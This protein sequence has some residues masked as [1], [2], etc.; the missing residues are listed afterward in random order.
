[1]T[2]GFTGLSIWLSRVAGSDVAAWVCGFVGLTI[3]VAT[4]NAVLDEL[5]TEGR[6]RMVAPGMWMID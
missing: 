5:Q 2:L 6:A 4:L 1:M 3:L